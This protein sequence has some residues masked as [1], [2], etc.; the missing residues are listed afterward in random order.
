MAT[1]DENTFVQV[2]INEGT[3]YGVFNDA[4]Y[5]SLDEFNALDDK[6]LA[7]LKADRVSKW[8]AFVQEESAKE[9]VLATPEELQAQKEVLV[10]QVAMLDQQI[11]DTQPASK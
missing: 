6:A 9:P 4:L 2:R 7:Q 3:D 10:A 8:V 1:F 11:F 5:F